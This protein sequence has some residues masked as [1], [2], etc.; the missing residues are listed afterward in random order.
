[1]GIMVGLSGAVIPG[2]LLSFTIFDTAKKGKVTGHLVMI[3]HMIWELGIILLILFGFGWVFTQHSSII[4]L[5]GGG[6]LAL[7]GVMMIRSRV[8]KI[9]MENPK[10]HSSLGGGIFYTAFNP[11][12]PPWWA[13]AGLALLIK[14][15]EV[16]GV[17]G[18]IIV[19]AGHWL[20]DIGYYTFVS[21]I[22]HRHKKY[23]NP[24]Q[25]QIAI[26]LGLFIIALGIFFLQQGLKKIALPIW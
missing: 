6:V 12:Q 20:S 15:L 8:E 24:R 9:E 16:L 25:R 7:M 21:F 14:G 11:T 18:V 10:V 23:V 3:G 22:I 17:L 26:A 13:T 1:M 4:Y 19:T 5:I 2:P